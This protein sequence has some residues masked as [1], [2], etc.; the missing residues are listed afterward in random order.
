MTQHLN[1]EQTLEDEATMRRLA[2]VIGGFIAFTAIG[3]LL[4]GLIAG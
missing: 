2:I 1:P 3:A 4:V